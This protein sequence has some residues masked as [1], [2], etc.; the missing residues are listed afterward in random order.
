MLE[1][2]A[3]WGNK[4]DLSIS[5]GF[6]NSQKKCLLEQLHQLKPNILVDDTNA[7]FSAL[8]SAAYN[9]SGQPGRVDIVLDNAGF[10]LVTDLVLAEMLIDTGLAAYVHFHAKTLPWFISDVTEEDF[11][12][13]LDMMTSSDDSSVS[14]FGLK[15]KSHLQSGSWVLKSDQ[16]W[17]LPYDFSEMK[18]WAPELYNDL[19][20][21]DLIFF[22]GDLNYRK[23]VGDRQWDPTTS[24]VK[25]LR[26]FHP[27]PICSL[28]ALKADV[29]VGLQK[30]LAEEVGKKDDKWQVNGNWAIISFCGEKL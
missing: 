25:S 10:E 26:G 13:T 23:L 11:A 9:R 2:V 22:K 4:C 14:D 16:F 15:C 7:V 6:E 29:V 17:T 24:F 18:S 12:W 20:K 27:S 5:Q 8:H 21:A 3:L 1:Q 30:G 28:R 19:A